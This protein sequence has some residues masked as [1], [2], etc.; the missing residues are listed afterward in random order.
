MRRNVKMKKV[1]KWLALWVVLVIV[2]TGLLWAAI[3]NG[4]LDIA[5]ISSAPSNPGSGNARLYYNTSSGYVSCLN[6]SGGS[7]FFAGTIP[8]ANGSSALGTSAISS[9]ACASAVTGT[10]TGATASTDNIVADFS[11]DPTSTTG[12]SPSSSGML[13]IIKYVTSNTVNFKVCNN[14]GGSITPG[15]VTLIWQV[16]R[17]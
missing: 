1:L 17:P 11:V 16:V 8:V 9:G 14:T 5:G 10:A 6:S 12:Y 3:V 4:Y 7:C 2:P 15:A 13:T